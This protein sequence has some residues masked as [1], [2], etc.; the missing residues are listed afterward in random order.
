MSVAEAICRLSL[1][2]RKRVRDGYA[3]H[4]FFGRL[5][6]IFGPSLSG[7]F[8]FTLYIYPEGDDVGVP[9]DFEGDDIRIIVDFDEHMRLSQILSS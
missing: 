6:G 7:G 9:I 8:S 3:W 4:D 2:W 1:G 5:I